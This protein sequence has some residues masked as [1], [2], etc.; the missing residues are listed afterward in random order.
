MSAR[1]LIFALA[2]IGS[3]TLLAAP[4]FAV[5]PDVD[6]GAGP[7]LPAPRDNPAY[8]PD[9]QAGAPLER[10]IEGTDSS[11]PDTVIVPSAP[12]PEPD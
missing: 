8:Q 12:V 10:D 9:D 6:S 1:N 7:E 2:A 3:A 4:A 5:E 11:V